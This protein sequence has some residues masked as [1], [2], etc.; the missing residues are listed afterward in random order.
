MNISIDSYRASIGVWHHKSFL[1]NI[2]NPKVLLSPIKIKLLLA[3]I[4][5]SNGV[6]IGALLLLRCGDIHPNPGPNYTTKSLSICHVNIQSLY[7]TERG[8]QKRKI[9]EIEA[10][11]L[12]NLKMDI[13]C[14]SETWL[15][16]EIKDEDIDI[17][18]YHIRRKD[19]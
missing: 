18:G 12:N 5:A 10:S 4:L 11:L 15:K 7:L 19:R 9:N 6:F 14:L 17:K 2:R 8:N 1:L 16:P 13:V 3:F